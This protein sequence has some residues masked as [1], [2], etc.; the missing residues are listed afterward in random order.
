MFR[1]QQYLSISSTL[2]KEFVDLLGSLEK[3]EST[4]KLTKTLHETLTEENGSSEYCTWYLRIITAAHLKSDIE[5]FQMFLEN[6]Y[7]DIATF[8]SRE[9]E[10]MGRECGM[11]QCIALAEAV[12]IQVNIEYLDGRPFK[13]EEGKGL[14]L[15]EFGNLDSSTKITLLYRPGHYDI[16]Y[17]K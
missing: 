14:T 8:C 13:H 17:K 10:P 7:S 3:D 4:E 2:R 11:L 15:H 9:V 1:H 16:L 12:G 5:R 6:E